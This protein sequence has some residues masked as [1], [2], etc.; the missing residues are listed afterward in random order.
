MAHPNIFLPLLGNAL[1]GVLWSDWKCWDYDGGA[2]VE[3]VE[4]RYESSAC[5]VES[6][7][8]SARRRVGAD[9]GRRPPC[10]RKDSS[11]TLD[12]LEDRL[13]TPQPGLDLLRG[14][15][16]TTIDGAAETTAGP[17]VAT[18]TLLA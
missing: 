5:G 16:T 17:T 11:W 2:S 13:P 3:V 7:D 14:S 10:L 18:P 1:E 9:G 8:A 15:S 4:G 12:V 6:V